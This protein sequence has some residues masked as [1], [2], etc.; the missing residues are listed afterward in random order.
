MSVTIYVEG[1]LDKENTYIEREYMDVLYPELDFSMELENDPFLKQDETGR[2]YQDTNKSRFPELNMANGNFET[3]MSQLGVNTY[4]ED[5]LVGSLDAK[6]TRQLLAKVFKANNVKPK[7]L[8][9]STTVQVEGNFHYFQV[10]SDYV[11]ERIKSFY[12]ILVFATRKGLGIYW[13]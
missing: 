13:A 12:E 5:G 8:P 2:I 9:E 10:G 11:S 7:G 4:H 1:G 6:E 3:V